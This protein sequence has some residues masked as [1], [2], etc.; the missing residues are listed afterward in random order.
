MSVLRTRPRQFKAQAAILALIGFGVAIFADW[1]GKGVAL[2][3]FLVA[4]ALW[5]AGRT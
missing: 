5:E 3:L 1:N 2:V 4:A